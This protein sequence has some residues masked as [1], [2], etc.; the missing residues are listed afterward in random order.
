MKKKNLK[1]LTLNPF[2]LLI[3]FSIIVCTE[4]MGQS[5]SN[6]STVWEV[7]KEQTD[8]G[9]V[10]LRVEGSNDNSGVTNI[11]YES[12]DK[13]KADVKARAAKLMWTDEKL[14][15]EIGN[16]DKFVPGGMINLY[17]TRG[18]IP[19]A[20]S[21]NF[22]LI[23]QDKTGKEI[24]RKQFSKEPPLGKDGE[25]YYSTNIMTLN[26]KIDPPFFVFVIDNYSEKK[27]KFEVK[28]QA[29]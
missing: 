23:I 27:F 6:A 22:T 8:Y 10:I 16:V 29:K 14:K 18:T 13:M 3:G 26:K 24:F 25:N 17:V 1:P 7:G 28:G 4:S 2:M 20:N 5:Y 15:E 11:A 19:A 12:P 21:G 9:T